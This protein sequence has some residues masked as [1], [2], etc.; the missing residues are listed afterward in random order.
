MSENQCSI[1]N[2][3]DKLT[4]RTI[5]LSSQSLHTISQSEQ[6]NE[7]APMDEVNTEPLNTTV[8]SSASLDAMDLDKQKYEYPVVNGEDTE[9]LCSPASSS[10]TLHTIDPTSPLQQQSNVE[11]ELDDV[12]PNHSINT[13][14]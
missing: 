9:P 4:V 5:A 6:E 12:R 10:Q 3:E 13:K 2:E 11:L 7:N 1:V 8:S 14:K